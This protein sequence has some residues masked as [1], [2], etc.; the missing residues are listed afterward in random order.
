MKRE[1]IYPKIYLYQRIVRA[2]MFIDQHYS[3]KIDLNN[4]SWEGAYSKFHFA[5]LFKKIYSQTPHQYLTRVRIDRAKILLGKPLPVSE[6]CFLVGFDSVSSFTGLF[7]RMAGITP[8]AYQQQKLQ[9]LEETLREP[10]K[11]IPNCF[12]GDNGAM[13][14]S[15]YGEMIN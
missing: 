3:G 4:I 13:K 8:A 10:L 9:L 12:A 6:V 2:K 15:N 5:R 14:K 11:F 1:K 7:K